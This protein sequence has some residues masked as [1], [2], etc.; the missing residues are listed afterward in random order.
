MF[1]LAWSVYNKPIRCRGMDQAFRPLTT[2]AEMQEP[3]ADP[4]V[5]QSAFP[6][7]MEGLYHF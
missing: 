1:I 3:L 2:D 5:P 6:E 7:P 4:G